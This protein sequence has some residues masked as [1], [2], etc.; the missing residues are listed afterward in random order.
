MLVPILAIYM[1]PNRGVHQLTSSKKSKIQRNSDKTHQFNFKDGVNIN[2]L[3]K[4]HSKM[5]RGHLMRREEPTQN[6]TWKEL[7]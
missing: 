2:S 6:K 7:L 3:R 1:N 4:S 5:S